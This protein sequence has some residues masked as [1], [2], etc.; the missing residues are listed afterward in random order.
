[1]EL[2]QLSDAGGDGLSSIENRLSSVK[3]GLKMR[4]S[5]IQEDR[6]E[7]ASE[8]IIDSSKRD[9]SKLTQDLKA[10]YQSL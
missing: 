7:K 1:M 5:I 4:G 9:P 2:Y 10:S 3:K 6:V 8:L